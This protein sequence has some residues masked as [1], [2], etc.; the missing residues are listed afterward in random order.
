MMRLSLKALTIAAG[1]LWGGAVFF[2]GIAN[3]VWPPYGAAFLEMTAS[4]YPGFRPSG[5][6]GSI[7]TGTSHAILDG[8]VCGLLFGWLY[9]RCLASTRAGESLRITV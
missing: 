6:V 1:I 9:N 5:T 3:A 2:C 8:A 4:L 7:L